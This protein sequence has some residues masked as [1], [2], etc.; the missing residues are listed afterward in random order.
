MKLI[1]ADDHVVVRTGL[2]ML[3]QN[4]VNGSS[5]I[6]QASTGDQVLN[7]LQASEYD[8][9]IMDMNMPGLNG[10]QLL[11]KVMQLQPTLH[12]LVVSVNSEDFFAAKCFQLGALGFV[13][14][15]SEDEELRKAI[16]S[17]VAGKRYITETQRNKI[18]RDFF[19]E[20]QTGNLFQ[21][22]SS[23]ELDVTLLLL[24][25]KGVLEV[26]NALSISPSTASTFKGRIFKKLGVSSLLE[27]DQLARRF[28]F[29]DDASTQH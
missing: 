14:K 19:R 25:G 26:A 8:V 2:E 17:V 6:E 29:I 22:L 11:E 5:T 15:K 18:T 4:A 16:E 7:K 3:A 1:I 21:S 10:L 12:V 9:L 20:E 23:R 28:G 27:L 24:K 13:P